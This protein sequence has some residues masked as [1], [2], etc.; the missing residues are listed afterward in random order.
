ML[1]SGEDRN[2]LNRDNLDYQSRT[3]VAVKSTDLSP[4]D[5]L[6]ENSSINLASPP[7]RADP[8]YKATSFG[9]ACAG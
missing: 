2:M 9:F 5:K 8:S 3:Q 4:H 6:N 1:E 7:G